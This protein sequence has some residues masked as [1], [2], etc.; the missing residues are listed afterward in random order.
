MTS[1]FSFRQCKTAPI[2]GHFET[3]TTRAYRA[4]GGEFG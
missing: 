4:P 1:G 2:N 3:Q